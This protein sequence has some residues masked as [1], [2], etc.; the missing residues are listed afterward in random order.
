MAPVTG[1]RKCRIRGCQRK[2]LFVGPA[3]TDIDPTAATASTT[4]T[5]IA[6]EATHCAVHWQEVGFSRQPQET[7][8]LQAGASLLQDGQQAV[9]QAVH[10]GSGT[11]GGNTLLGGHQAAAV[12]STAG[13]G[14]AGKG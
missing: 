5:T 3:D 2:T 13:R 1:S 6:S 7:V 4:A 11:E 8:S 9:Q 10:R 12:G 14:R